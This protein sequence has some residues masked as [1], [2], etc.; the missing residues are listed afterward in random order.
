MSFL[1]STACVRLKMPGVAKNVLMQ[2]AEIANDQGYAF[3]SIDTLCMRT[4]WGRTAV[5]EALKYL[6]EQKVLWPDKTSGR[7]TKYWITPANWTGERFPEKLADQYASRTGPPPGLVRQTDPTR[8]PAGPDPS[9]KRTLI[10][11]NTNELNTPPTPKGAAS[12]FDEFWKTYPKKLAEAA[13]RTQW[14]KLAPDAP[15][16][17]RIIEALKAQA[18]GEAWRRDGGR[19]VPKASAWL[20]GERW[21]DQVGEAGGGVVGGAGLALIEGSR[22]H[23]EQMAVQLGIKPWDVMEQFP[24]YKA[25]VMGAMAERRQVRAA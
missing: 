12:G 10:P 24:V 9:A 4:C 6:E 19:Y 7:N 5:I 2:L 15:L 18:A 3:P 14:D 8:P 22:A 1:I 25:R 20:S 13:A 11:P 17:A 21:R 23:V 16:Q